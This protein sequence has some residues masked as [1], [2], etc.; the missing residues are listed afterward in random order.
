MYNDERRRV[1]TSNSQIILEQFGTS[2][3]ITM[4]PCLHDYPSPTFQ[5]DPILKT[6]AAIFHQL[7]QHT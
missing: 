1:G 5:Y 2:F 7:T 4:P 6:S 3:T